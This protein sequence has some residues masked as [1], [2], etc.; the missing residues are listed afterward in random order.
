MEETRLTFESVPV[1]AKRRSRRVSVWLCVL[2]A[3][4]AAAFGILFTSIYYVNRF[5]ELE[6]VSEAIEPETVA[7]GENPNTTAGGVI[8]SSGSI[9]A[10][11][12]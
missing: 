4:L 10:P 3:V 8:N 12:A 11:A 1:K 6:P 9:A 5:S 7:D 2:C